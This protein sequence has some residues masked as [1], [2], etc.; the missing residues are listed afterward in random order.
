M[1]LYLQ[2]SIIMIPIRKKELWEIEMLR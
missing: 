1:I 2:Y